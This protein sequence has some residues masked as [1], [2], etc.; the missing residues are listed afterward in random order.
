MFKPVLVNEKVN[1]KIF[2]NK[3]NNNEF[4]I[5]IIGCK[6]KEVKFIALHL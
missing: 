5:V 3:E 2:Q 4:K 1:L 6:S